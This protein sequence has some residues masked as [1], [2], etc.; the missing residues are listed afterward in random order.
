MKKH[1]IFGWTFLLLFLVSCGKDQ[2]KTFP[3][4]PAQ[5]S[6]HVI[7]LYSFSNGSV[8]DLSGNNNHL[9]NTSAASSTTD[10]N[11][12]Q[13]CAFELDNLT[14]SNE[15]SGTTNTS[16]LNNLSEFSISLW[17]Q[18]LDTTR[19]GSDYEGLIQRGDG[20]NCPDRMGQWSLGLYDCR[21]AVFGR[22]SSVWDQTI[23]ST[24]VCQDEINIRTDNWFHI[25]VTFKNIGN[26][27][28]IFRN[29]IWQNSSTGIANCSSGIA[30]C[31]D[32]GDLFIGKNF[33]GKI[34]DLII[35]NKSVDQQ[36]VNSLFN[37]ASCCD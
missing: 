1:L 36:E 24:N 8:N 33:T 6:N 29:G 30:T 26:E 32:V 31:Q 23:T 18:P 21:K 14:D 20:L 22:T 15:F 37:M 27:M 11:G 13:N 7:A 28:K 4:V 16:F 19:N 34:D 9:I 35:L 2:Y 5:I 17:C 25:V 3:C 10:R 12:N